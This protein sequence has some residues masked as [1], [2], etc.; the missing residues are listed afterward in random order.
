MPCETTTNALRK[1]QS[2]YS[3]IFRGW[4][5]KGNGYTVLQEYLYSIFY[6]QTNPNGSNFCI[7]IKSCSGRSSIPFLMFKVDHCSLNC[8]ILKG[9]QS[10]SLC[11][12]KFNTFL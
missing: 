3:L 7:E 6:V 5:F 8:Y 1:N 10:S 12:I 2:M 9:G 4:N 11:L